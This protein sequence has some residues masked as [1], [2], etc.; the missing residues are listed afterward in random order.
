MSRTAFIIVKFNRLAQ[1]NL[2][3]LRRGDIILLINMY[4]GR[5]C[6]AFTGIGRN[7]S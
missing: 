6:G 3:F 2:I 4:E 1:D 7:V 5:A